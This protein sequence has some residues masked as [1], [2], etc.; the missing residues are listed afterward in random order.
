[1]K[2]LLVAAV[3]V[4]C[5]SIFAD[6]V[7]RSVFSA[8][9]THFPLKP[10]K[11]QEP[12]PGDA[13]IKR[14]GWVE[15]DLA[16]EREGWHELLTFDGGNRM[17]I[18]L[19]GKVVTRAF[20]RE[21]FDG[22]VSEGKKGTKVANLYLTKGSHVLKIQSAQFPASQPGTV[23]LVE[24]SDPLGEINARFVSDS[25]VRLRDGARI[26]VTAGDA[27]EPRTY[28]IVAV[29]HGYPATNTLA[30]LDFAKGVSTQKA[31]LMFPEEGVWMLHLRDG[32]KLSRPSD[33][34]LGRVA[35]IDTATVREPGRKMDLI[36][37]I[38]CVNL[39][40]MGR[41]L[42]VSNGFWEAFG[43]T[44]VVETPFGAYR[45]G[46]DNL[47]RDIRLTTDGKSKSGFSFDISVPDLKRPYLLEL[48][49]PDDDRRTV[50][51]IIASENRHR[52]AYR[53][54]QLGNGYET[55]DFYPL[56]RTMKKYSVVFWADSTNAVV[57]AMSMNPGMRAAASRIRVWSLSDVPGGLEKTRADGREV[58]LWLEEPER[59][60]ALGR[61]FSQQNEIS[62]L[63]GQ[64][65]LGIA[66]TAALAKYA[67]YTT[68]NLTVACYGMAMW[69]TRTLQGWRALPFN[70][71]RMLALSCEKYGLRFVPELHLPNHYYFDVEFAQ[72]VERPE[73]LMIYSRVGTCGT[74]GRPHSWTSPYWNPLHPAVQAKYLDIMND[75]M[76][77]VGDSPAFG[78]IGT[79]LMKWR[80]C[81]WS[82]LPS[83]NW[84]Y[85]DWTVHAYERATGVKVPVDDKDPQRFYK[86]CKFLT[87]KE[88]VA[89]WRAWRSGMIGDYQVRMRD[90]IQA[91]HPQ[92]KLY[93]PY[94]G[95]ME[96]GGGMDGAF[97]FEAGA[98]TLETFEETGLGAERMK[99]TDGICVVSSGASV[100]RRYSSF[101]TDFR[102]HATS[103]DPVA[104]AL[105]EGSGVNANYFEDHRAI[106]IDLLGLPNLKPGEYCGASEP[107]GEL[108]LDTYSM[109]LAEGDMQF[110]RFGGLCYP[111][112]H[113]DESKAW[114]RTFANLPARPFT[115]FDKAVDPVAVRF[116]E[117]KDERGRDAFY[118]YAVNRLPYPC[119]VTLTLDGASSVTAL[120]TEGRVALRDGA[121][122]VDL[123][124]YGLKGFVAPLGASL[125]DAVTEVP[126]GTRREI[127][128]MLASTKTVQDLAARLCTAQERAYLGRQLDEAWDA[129]GKGRYWYAR[130]CLISIDMVKIYEKVG[131]W[132]E[133]LIHRKG[134]IDKL[135]AAPRIRNQSAALPL[136]EKDEL[137]K[138]C[139]TETRQVP[140]ESINAAWRFDTLLVSPDGSFRFEL[141]TDVDGLYSVQ[142]GVASTTRSG[143]LASVNGVAKVK[144]IA[145]PGQAEKVI[146]PPARAKDGKLVVDVRAGDPALGIYALRI[147]PVLR[148]VPSPNWL[149]VGPFDRYA[150]WD[151]NEIKR[152]MTTD[153]GPEKNPSVDAVYTKADGGTLRWSY[154]NATESRAIFTMSQEAGTS[155]L[156]RNGAL[157]QELYYA[158]T[159]IDSP[160]ERDVDI[161]VST[162]WLTNIYVNGE[163]I[164]SVAE[165][166]ATKTGPKAFAVE[167]PT[168]YNTKGRIHL[169]K[170]RNVVLAKVLGGN[171]STCFS[172]WVNDPGDLTIDPPQ[173]KGV[174]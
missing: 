74:P 109:S 20:G 73:D 123:G 114:A 124:P 52:A 127:R 56:S 133:G 18:W 152:I 63:M 147:E 46:G 2:R 150:R 105:G 106:P 43:K 137:A 33:L 21:S 90:A 165:D 17:T 15:Y 102:G 82:Y 120:G 148:P 83:I 32:G 7:S 96:G 158:L 166:D 136:I 146:L 80:G 53:N 103:S 107:A 125:A 164:V 84:G 51:V 79:R 42:S 89:S 153:Y 49:Y 122:T 36:H 104:Y 3:L 171:M 149:T 78:G 134:G 159:T 29:K 1:M 38:D 22:C 112:A 85:G 5:W 81:T 11:W 173:K 94:M 174:E 47:D 98:T 50:N 35:V 161:Q 117:A 163:R 14:D 34:G 60:L 19:D 26:A 25:V 59:W 64:H 23:K 172:F 72:E 28:E 140:S 145:V 141:P 118:F 9:R 92:A 130:T 61:P 162:D 54:A 135:V 40:D 58:A 69:N 55:G 131:S 68:L 167:F 99:R 39:T 24:S 71:T 37:D 142:V 65:L 13:T 88:N 76:D 77:S 16:I 66:R 170:G 44:R 168:W 143:V 151:T 57:A 67:G 91:R 6:V 128:D 129:F 70:A 144:E 4:G 110:V 48:E 138:A 126:D 27:V 93:I 160:V 154:E 41:R 169:K 45:E 30:R 87:A 116:A 115:L 12:K 139:R 95:G 75:L 97:G 100:G 121:L 108:A 10:E 86:R 156:L 132:P 155:F 101:L 62:G 111:F 113:P 31:T 119:R 157:P 8:D